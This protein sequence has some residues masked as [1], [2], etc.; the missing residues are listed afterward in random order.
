MIDA[1]AMT[2][3]TVASLRVLTKLCRIRESKETIDNVFVQIYVR[4]K[5]LFNFCFSD[6]IHKQMN[7]HNHSV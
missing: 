7:L 2:N 4:N 5:F 3:A 6:F 1:F